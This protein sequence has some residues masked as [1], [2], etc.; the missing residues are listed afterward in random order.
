VTVLYELAVN[1]I[2]PAIDEAQQVVVLHLGD[3]DPSGID[4]TRDLRPAGTVLKRAA[5]RHSYC[6]EYIT[7][8]LRQE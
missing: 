4:M 3:H 2:I 7:P 8:S 1:E 6:L 5:D